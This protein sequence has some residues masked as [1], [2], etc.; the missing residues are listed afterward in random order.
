LDENQIDHHLDV[1]IHVPISG[2]DVDVQEYYHILSNQEIN[3]VSHS[4]VFSEQSFSE[5][6]EQFYQN[7][8]I[9]NFQPFLKPST[10]ENNKFH[11]NEELL[12]TYNNHGLEFEKSNDEGKVI[13][14]TFENQDGTSIELYKGSFLDIP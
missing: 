11:L 1:D 2:I 8:S 13:L 10:Q 12:I 7:Q 4:D 14:D 3:E 5:F 6:Q 9:E